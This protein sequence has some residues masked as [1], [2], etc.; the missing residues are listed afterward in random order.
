VITPPLAAMPNPGSTYQDFLSQQTIIQARRVQQN[1]VQENVPPAVSINVNSSFNPA[2]GTIV[3]DSRPIVQPRSL[4]SH[5][6]VQ[7]FSYSNPQIYSSSAT[8]ATEHSSNSRLAIVPVSSG[9]SPPRS[10][11]RETIQTARGFPTLPASQQAMPMR[12]LEPS[13]NLPESSEQKQETKAIPAERIESF[14]PPTQLR[15]IP[16]PQID[17]EAL[18]TQV[19]RKLMRRLVVERE[20]R[21]QKWH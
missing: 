9:A 20:R 19:E 11:T 8:P 13:Q 1:I 17:V 10:G 2:L 16:Q 4:T 18:A 21:G 12:A 15:E 6:I 5:N 14:M 3:P 7:S